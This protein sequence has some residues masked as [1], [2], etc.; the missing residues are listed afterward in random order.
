MRTETTEMSFF[1][2]VARFRLTGHK[3]NEGMR[4]ELVISDITREIELG[5][6]ETIATTPTPELCAV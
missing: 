1:R 2:K 5:N 6:L 3:C 4:Q